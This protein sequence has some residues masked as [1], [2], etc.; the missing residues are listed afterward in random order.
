M[1]ATKADAT[2][3]SEDCEE[4]EEVNF[5]LKGFDYYLG[6]GKEV[7]RFVLAFVPFLGVE[8]W[9]LF[10]D[11]MF[12]KSCMG[13]FP[14]SFLSLEDSSLMGIGLMSSFEG[15]S[16]RGCSKVDFLFSFEDFPL[17]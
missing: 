16:T 17:S 9:A 14:K 4:F 5:Q 11:F 1:K 10:L 6:T 8:G 13:F 12:S 2:L 7:T 3:E 15:G